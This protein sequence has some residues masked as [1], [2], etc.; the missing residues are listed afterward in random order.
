MLFRSA[1]IGAE[2]GQ[3]SPEQLDAL[4]RKEIVQWAKIIDAAKIVAE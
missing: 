2:P 1:K 4:I 3:G